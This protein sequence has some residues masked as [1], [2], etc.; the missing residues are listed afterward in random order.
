MFYIVAVLMASLAVGVSAQ[1]STK[2]DTCY[3]YD[4][5][6]CSIPFQL[7]FF[8]K[9]LFT[10]SCARHDIC[11]HCGVSYLIGRAT[12]DLSFR[13]DTTT[14]C[15]KRYIN[16][17]LYYLPG[18]AQPPYAHN[19][20]RL[21]EVVDNHKG[22][23]VLLLEEELRAFKPSQSNPGVSVYFIFFNIPRTTRVLIKWIELMKDDLSNITK[24]GERATISESD[25]LKNV[26]GI[27][28]KIIC[29][30]IYAATSL[31]GIRLDCEDIRYMACHFFSEVYYL[32]V[33]VFGG[34]HYLKAPEFYCK[35]DF[36]P[37]CLPGSP[38]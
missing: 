17:V 8:F 15:K 5:D 12:C 14:S 26:E 24:V 23:L 4:V 2:N 13:N 19:R 11:Y 16:T 38:L 29:K 27:A 30:T 1:G 34:P 28:E 20:Q 31:F 33:H 7:P 18:V 3:R 32:G 6:G 10:H 35:E 37:K 22:E 9:D 21:A 25:D 36:V